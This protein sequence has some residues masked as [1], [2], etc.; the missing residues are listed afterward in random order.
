M[1]IALSEESV[2]ADALLRNADTA[3]Y[4]AKAGGKDS[5][6]TFEP[7]MHSR[8][9]DR[10]ELRTELTQAVERDE[11]L[12]EYQPIVSLEAGGTVGFEALVRWQHPR[13]GRLGP[14]QFIGL[15]EETGLIVPIGR[16]VLERACVQLRRWQLALPTP[17]PLY[18]SVNVSIRQLREQSF[19]VS[20]AEIL[21]KTGLPPQS[22]VLEITEGLLADD[23]DAIVTRL[24][25]LKALGLRI[26]ID[27]FG[28]GQGFLF[29]R[30]LA[31]DQVEALVE[32]D[33]IRRA[34]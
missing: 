17:G 32:L 14:D 10:L 33:D 19:P 28:T 12:L 13:R 23:N 15:A 8:V 30:P 34:A 18:V 31:V 2:D 20:V 3:M 27:D 29:S 16:W 22:L 6:H 4:A 5:V 26:A 25:E 9:L 21:E 11:L 24:Q 7:S 1:G